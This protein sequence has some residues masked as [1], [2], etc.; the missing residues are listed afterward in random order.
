[1]F[2]LQCA[3]KYEGNSLW[4]A[5]DATTIARSEEDLLEALSILKETGMKNDLELSKEKTKIMVIRG[6][7]TAEKKKILKWKKKSNT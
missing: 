1:M 3:F 4:L 6:Q 7:N 2:C 5:D